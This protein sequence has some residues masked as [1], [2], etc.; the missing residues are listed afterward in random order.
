VHQRCTATHAPVILGPVP[1]TSVLSPSGS[2]ALCPPHPG[3]SRDPGLRTP[4]QLVPRETGE[5]RRSL[6]STRSVDGRVSR[7]VRATRPQRLA[8]S[9]RSTSPASGGRVHQPPSSRPKC[10][11]TPSGFRGR[12]NQISSDF[13]P[14]AFRSVGQRLP[15]LTAP[16]PD[17]YC[18][19]T[20][21]REVRDVRSSGCRCIGRR[22]RRGVSA[23]RG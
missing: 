11:I 15:E 16:Q 5:V 19:R 20:D 6:G 23:E 17:L 22:G 13:K 9:R 18:I 8:A 12:R 7:A 4:S 1:R 3:E 21:T 14:L 10:R 2:P